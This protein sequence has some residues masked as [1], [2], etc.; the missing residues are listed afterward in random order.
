MI[1]QEDYLNN[2]VLTYSDQNYKIRQ[3]ETG[4]VYDE[5]IDLKPCAYTYEETDEKIEN[6]EDEI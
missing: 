4:A 2:L 1:I 6:L 3:V 5:A